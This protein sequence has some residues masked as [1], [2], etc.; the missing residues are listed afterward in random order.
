MEEKLVKIYSYQLDRQIIDKVD[1]M[2]GFRSAV[3]QQAAYNAGGQQNHCL[4]IGQHPFP[5]SEGQQWDSHT[6]Q[7]WQPDGR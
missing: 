3:Q 7:D 5:L 2:E 4:D 1:Q 6:T